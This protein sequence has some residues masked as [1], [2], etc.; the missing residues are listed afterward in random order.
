MSTFPLLLAAYTLLAC[1]SCK[2]D[3]SATDAAEAL[4]F[5][6][7]PD[8]TPVWISPTDPAFKDIHRIPPFSFTDQNGKQVTQNDISGKICV[9]NFFFIRCK[10]I[11]PRMTANMH[12][13][14]DIHQQDTGLLFLS[15]SVDPDNDSV[16]VLHQYAMDNK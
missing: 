11:C 9:V 15:H 13:L 12:R 6:N 2:N 4:P 14:Q 3:H 7:E 10:N 16:P 8:W 5:F 1:A